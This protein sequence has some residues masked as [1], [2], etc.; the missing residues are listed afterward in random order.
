M[1]TRYSQFA[2]QGIRQDSSYE[3]IPRRSPAST[4]LRT[5]RIAV[6]EVCPP[7]VSSARDRRTVHCERARSTSHYGCTR[8]TDSE[9]DAGRISLPSISVV[10]FPTRT[11]PRLCIQAGSACSTYFSC[12][13]RSLDL[14]VLSS[15][16]VRRLPSDLNQEGSISERSARLAGILCWNEAVPKI[17]GVEA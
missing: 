1:R 4:G 2:D 5:C 10:S 7:V 16:P 9:Y 13:R 12:S 3:L 8:L 11:V 17:Q 15:T 14:V 6:V